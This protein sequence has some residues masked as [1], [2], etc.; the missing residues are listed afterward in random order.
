M[1]LW[2]LSLRRARKKIEGTSG[3]SAPPQALGRWNAD[4]SLRK[5]NFALCSALVS[6]GSSSWL[7]STSKIC[8]YWSG[9]S[10]GPL[11]SRRYE[12]I[13]PCKERLR[14]P[15]QFTLNQ[16]KLEIKPAG[17]KEDAGTRLFSVLLTEP[18]TTGTN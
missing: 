17:E 13:S 5:L 2:L 6:S 11:R 18:D 8:S 3:W 4:S 14:E 15:W 16:R 1:K 7:P 12:S 9:S 10:A